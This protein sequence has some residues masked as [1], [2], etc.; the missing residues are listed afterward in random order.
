[1]RGFREVIGLAVVIVGVYL[2]LNTVVVGAG[3]VYLVEHPEFFRQ[4]LDRVEAGHWHLKDRRRSA[5]P[6]CFTVIAISLIIFPKLALGLSG[7]ET[8][9]AVMPLVHGQARRRPEGAARPHPQRPQTADH[10]RPHHVRVSARLVGGRGVSGAAG[11]PHPRGCRRQ[12]EP[13]HDG[14]GFEG[15]R[16]GPGLPRPR[17][18]TPKG[19]LLPFFGEAFGTVYDMSTVVILWF[20]GASAMAGLL[21]LVPQYLPRYGMAPEWS[22]ATRPLVLLFT[23]INLV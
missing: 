3:V 9:V 6:A 10:R 17:R 19:N 14:Q 21:N 15:P 4:F 5:A 7:F 22:R 11:A 2:V 20:A 12:R 8:G 13:G 16:P 23:A 18:R 1:M